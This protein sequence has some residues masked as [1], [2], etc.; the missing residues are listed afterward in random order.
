M[1]TDYFNF[2]T[3]LVRKTRARAEA[4][5]AL[6][7]AIATGLGLL[8]SKAQFYEGR[9]TYCGTSTGVAGAY[10]LTTPFTVAL[11]DGLR[12]RWRPVDTNVGA[13]T[14]TVGGATIP[15]T[16]W[17]GNALGGGECAI[18][19]DV[20]TVYHLTSNHHRIVNPHTTIGTVTVNNKTAVTT[21]DTTPDVLTNKVTV[22][23]ALVK[24][25]SNPTGNATVD[26]SP[27]EG[28]AALLADLFS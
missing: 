28:Q 26:I 6:F 12:L 9:V 21:G 19:C 22:S 17:G 5:N 10:I 27:D 20:E 1:S 18:G 4:V 16:D 3:A 23:G 2:T 14:L 13:V 24:T 7:Q 11:S 15:V 8:P 25:V